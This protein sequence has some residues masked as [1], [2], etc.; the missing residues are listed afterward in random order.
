MLLA[1]GRPLGIE[2][3]VLTVTEGNKPATSLYEK[4]GFIA[5]GTEPDAIRV[6][7][8]SYG[9]THMYRRLD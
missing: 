1:E 7:G 3:I 5:F 4:S 9:K 6:D 8:I 2:Q